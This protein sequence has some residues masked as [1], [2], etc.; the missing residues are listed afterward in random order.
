MSDLTIR[1]LTPDTFNDFAALVE[2]NKG[3][4]ASCWCIHFHPDCPEKGQTAEGNRALKQRLVAE[5]IAHAALVYDD[6]TAGSF[7]PGER[8]VADGGVACAGEVT[9]CAAGGVGFVAG[10]PA[11]EALGGGGHHGDRRLLVEGVE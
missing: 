9:G 8:L 7:L 4:F 5:G 1:A 3:M 11:T 10:E 2:R 6:R